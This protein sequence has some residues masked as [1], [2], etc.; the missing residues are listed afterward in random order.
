MKIQ[1]T[2]RQVEVTQAIKEFIDNKLSR[3]EKHFDHI[4]RAHVILTVTK[5]QHTAEANLDISGAKIFAQ[6]TEKDM[7]AAIDLLI[8]KLDRQLIKHKEKISNHNG[9][10][11]VF[12]E[13]NVETEDSSA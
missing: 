10:K 4:S 8:D 12:I 5:G 7:Y 9:Q 6:D 2:G 3:L 1:I 13:N 11:P